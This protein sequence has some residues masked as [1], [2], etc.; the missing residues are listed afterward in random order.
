[1]S[2]GNQ[3]ESGCMAELTVLPRYQTLAAVTKS[4]ARIAGLHAHASSFILP[5]GRLRVT[6]SAPDTLLEVNAMPKN[7]TGNFK[8]I[9]IAV[10]R[11]ALRKHY[12]AGVCTFLNLSLIRKKYN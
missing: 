7:Q 1:M 8:G 9:I 4:M 5:I 10:T 11:N 6:G 3:I 2:R 12:A